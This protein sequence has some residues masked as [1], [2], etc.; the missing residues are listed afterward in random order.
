MLCAVFKHYC[1]RVLVR[2]HGK[3]LFMSAIK[4]TQ[5]NII[6]RDGSGDMCG[7]GST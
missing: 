1:D 6:G 3:F 5:L 4:I 7:L 2:I